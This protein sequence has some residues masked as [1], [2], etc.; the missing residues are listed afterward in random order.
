MLRICIGLTEPTPFTKGRKQLVSFHVPSIRLDTASWHQLVA[1][2][3][4]LTKHASFDSIWI[5]LHL[6]IRACVSLA[7]CMPSISTPEK[8]LKQVRIQNFSFFVL[9]INSQDTCDLNFKSEKA[10]LIQI[11]LAGLNQSPCSRHCWGHWTRF[12]QLNGGRQSSYFCGSFWVLTWLPQCCGHHKLL[13]SSSLF[14]SR[15]LASLLTSFFLRSA[16]HFVSVCT[17]PAQFKQTFLTFFVSHCKHPPQFEKL[18]TFG[19]NLL[20]ELCWPLFVLAGIIQETFFMLETLFF[21]K[22]ILQCTMYVT[23]TSGL[24]QRGRC[25]WN[26][27]HPYL[28]R[29]LCSCQPQ[30]IQKLQ[31]WRRPYLSRGGTRIESE[32]INLEFTLEW[33]NQ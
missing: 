16:A 1:I 19:M 15:C 17:N 31:Y 14:I 21:H 28:H 10:T 32:V 12:T 23:G 7:P 33:V 26:S 2:C 6:H 18:E 13:P 25:L 30:A 20:V 5:S 24:L 29:L 11:S 27:R 4:H 22:N 3:C 8:K 9:R